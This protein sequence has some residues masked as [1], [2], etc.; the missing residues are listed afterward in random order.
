[1]SSKLA[2]LRLAASMLALGAAQAVHGQATAPSSIT[3]P[4][5]RPNDT[6]KGVALAVPE[7]GELVPPAGSEGLAVR[8]DHVVVD[9]GF[10]E[11]ATTTA[12]IVAPLQG[13]R[14]T[15]AEVYKAASEIEAVHARAGYVLARVVVP[16]QSL[17]DG[18]TLRIVV[19]DGFIED[20]D[21]S[22]VPARVRHAV[23]MRV[24]SL[25]G[26]HHVKLSQIEQP[27]LIASDVPGLTL[28]STLTRGTQA[29]ATRLV[30][31]GRQALVSGQ[32]GADN[33]L[34]SSLGTYGFNL[35]LSLNSALG[36]GEQIYGF[37]AS[38]YNVSKLFG[39]NVPV[40]VLGGGVVVPIGEGRLTFN[41]EATFSRT[42][43]S[44][45]EGAPQSQGKL[46]RLTMRAGYTVFKTR[47]RTLT[48]NAVVEQLD[49]TN[50]LPAFGV[51]ISHDRFMATRVGATYSAN[52]GD[53]R[54]II[55]NGQFS[56]G[57]GDLGALKQGELPIGTT[58]SRQGASLDF[59]KFEA[60]LHAKLPLSRDFQ[61]TIV[62]KGQTS[63]G[64]ALFR[65][66]QTALEGNDALSAYVGGVTAVDEAV[67]GRAELGGTFS[68]AQIAVALPYIFAAAGVGRIDQ[69]TILEPGSISAG[70]AG[71]GLRIAINGTGLSVSAEYAHGFSDYAPL[72]SVDRVN[73]SISVR[74]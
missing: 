27:L 66:E 21:V 60:A 48:V 30:L 15:L 67:L 71:A 55:L 31:A 68:V 34:A 7:A 62:A 49:E 32:I 73:A 10:A 41:P 51:D 46:R 5:L 16:P 63:F 74:F 17:V 35:Q 9:G 20:V 29:G 33:G 69:P 2:C 6:N 64:K 42:Q 43:P 40:R 47:S 8:I 25:K 12:A 58:Y 14:V 65:S 72:H 54:A 13:R 23:E 4:T 11:L 19:I 18:G 1:M 50:G 26:R 24:A 53:G 36:V 22:G 28:S 70:S 44:V 3:P 45:T 38:G 56:H 61:L 52:L 39:S 37:A 57:L 59:S